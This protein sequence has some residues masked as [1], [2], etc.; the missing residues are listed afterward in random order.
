MARLNIVI[1]VLF[2]AMLTVAFEADASGIKKAGKLYE[3]ENYDEAVEQ[4]DRV[5]LKNPE[6]SF[7]QYNRAAALYRKR[8]FAEAEEGFLKSLSS[9][10]E[11][12]E[13]K[14]VYNVGNSKYRL[15]EETE[16]RDPQTALNNYKQAVQYYQRAV[17]LAPGDADAKYNYE[18]TN[19]K[20]KELQ[21]KNGAG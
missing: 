13:E 2:S 15:G 19:K 10:K 3:E 16:G 1:S 12:I 17:E 21:E 7:A 4:Y 6:D 5:L 8:A 9:G 14:S 11:E 20:I 18:L